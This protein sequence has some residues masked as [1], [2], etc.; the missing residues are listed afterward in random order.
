ME[1]FNIIFTQ[2]PMAANARTNAAALLALH[3]IQ[4][5]VAAHRNVRLV[6]VAIGAPNNA[7]R[8]R[9]VRTVKIRVNVAT[10]RRD[11]TRAQDS[12]IVSPDGVGRNVARSVHR[13]RGDT[14]VAPNATVSM[15]SVRMTQEWVL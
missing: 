3:A 4:K 1:T 14:S 11:A 15:A 12:V 7:V 2:V 8:I 6:A 10:M 5:L 13:E 9:L